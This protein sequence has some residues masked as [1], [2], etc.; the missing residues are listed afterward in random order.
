MRRARRLVRGGL[1]V[2][3][4]AGLASVLG[5][6]LALA[7]CGSSQ[8][9]P[10][11]DAAPTVAST[12]PAAA[13]PGSPTAVPDVRAVL[14]V[15][16][17]R[18]D[19]AAPAGSRLDERGGGRL[20]VRDVPT[21][22]GVLLTAPEGAT[23]DVRVDGSVLVLRA[24]RPTAPPTASTP[25]GEPTASELPSAVPEPRAI[26]GGLARLTPAP[27]P[28]PGAPAG[29]ALRLTPVAGTVTLWAGTGEPRSARWG[30]HD[31]GRSLA[32]DPS[33]W[34][35]DAGT[36]GAEATWAAVVRAHPDAATS[37]MHDQLT[38]HAIGA[39]HKATWNLEPWRPDVGLLATIAA[40][41]NPTTP[42]PTR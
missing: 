17:V 2:G 33:T 41:C 40:R 37:G 35:R 4:A 24:P 13:S 23:L 21:G 14:A 38:C 10:V 32:V 19:V 9:S 18:L 8:P 5:L 34:A 42:T 26:V 16:S 28:E 29:R 20:T 15:G 30:T 25:P 31:G 27:T 12:A 1:T 3:I 11:P 36:A 7:G 6:T 39:P 22:G